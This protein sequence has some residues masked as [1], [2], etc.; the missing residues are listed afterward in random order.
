MMAQTHIS[1]PYRSFIIAQIAATTLAAL[2]WLIT[3]KLMSMDVQIIYAGI[4]ESGIVLITSIVFLALFSPTKNRPVATLAT[5]WSVTSFVR[6]CSALGA[7]SLL[8]YATIFGLRPLL[9]SFFLNAIF[10]L[11][12]ETRIVTNQ[13]TNLTR[14]NK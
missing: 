4:A 13:L 10:L 6:F 7:S 9:F 3:T 5:L 12:F 11:I 2:V 8:Y 14:L 1:L